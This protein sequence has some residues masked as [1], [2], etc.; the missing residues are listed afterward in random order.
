MTFIYLF[1]YDIII[2]DI[3]NL[4]KVKNNRKTKKEFT[5]LNLHG[6]RSEEYEYEEQRFYIN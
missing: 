5:Q 2:V 3:N 4:T 6:Q 1:I